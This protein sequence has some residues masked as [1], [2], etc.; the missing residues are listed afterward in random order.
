MRDLFSGYLNLHNL[1]RTLVLD[2]LA[3]WRAGS[4]GGIPERMIACAPDQVRI[5]P[6]IWTQNECLTNLVLPAFEAA[7]KLP[8][9]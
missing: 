2:I 6:D 8:D 1:D 7:I 5:S 9:L 4:V 3:A